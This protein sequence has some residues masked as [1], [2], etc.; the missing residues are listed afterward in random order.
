MIFFHRHIKN[1][2]NLKARS[3]IRKPYLARIVSNAHVQKTSRIPLAGYV[4]EY[5]LHYSSLIF[6]TYKDF[7]DSILKEIHNFGPEDKHPAPDLD[8]SK[9][10]FMNKILLLAL[11]DAMQRKHV[12]CNLTCIFLIHCIQIA[13]ADLLPKDRKLFQPVLVV[14]LIMKLLGAHNLTDLKIVKMS[15]VVTFSKL[16]MR[17]NV[18]NSGFT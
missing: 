8:G 12:K 11:A 17:N 10:Q 5:L 4:F 15:V 3:L 6:Q 13:D 2:W 1:T 7:F 14:M 9:V 18:L 16:M